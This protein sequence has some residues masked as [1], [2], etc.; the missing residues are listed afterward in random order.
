MRIGILTFHRSINN[1]AVMQ[2]YSLSKR[3]KKEFPDATVEVIDYHMPLVEENVYNTSFHHYFKG[4]LKHKIGF[5]L[6]IRSSIEQIKQDRNRKESF[7]NAL[8]KLPLSPQTIY[9][10]G[11]EELV[12]YINTSYDVVVAGS[13]AIWNYSVRGFPNPYFLSKEVHAK[14]LSYAASCYGMNYEKIPDWQNKEIKDILDTYSFLGTRDTESESFLHSIGCAVEPV[15][16]CDPTAFL[17]VEDLPI[18]ADALKQKLISR[19]FD[20]SKTT[21]GIM[22]SEAM[23]KMIRKMFGVQYQLVSLYNYNSLCDINLNDLS[24]YEWAYVFRFFNVTVTTYFHG[25]MLS[26]RNGVPVLCIALDNEYSKKHVTKVE[27]LLHRLDLDECYWK[28]DYRDVN[29]NEIKNKIVELIQSDM[30]SQLME[31]MDNEA[32]T[33]NSFLKA[34]DE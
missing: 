31:R 17:D 7:K 16:T 14:K 9:S 28:T 2:C 21:I 1:G 26:L 15:H 10:N 32:M 20:E 29:H 3:L 22:G 13:D 12:N 23:C 11:I 33:F 18:N 25:T 24:P 19:G 34:I 30:R 5:L 8:T 4:S 27:D 6:N